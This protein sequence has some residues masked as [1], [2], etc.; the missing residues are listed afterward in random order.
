MRYNNT[1]NIIFLLIVGFII[2]EI[3]ERVKYR[4]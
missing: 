1:K 4:T 3:I 2:I